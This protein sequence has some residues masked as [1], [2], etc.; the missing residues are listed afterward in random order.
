MYPEEVV[1]HGR[2][3]TKSK[4]KGEAIVTRQPFMFT[5]ALDPKTGR[6]IDRRHELFGEELRGKVFVFPYPVGS[7]SAGMWLLEAVRLGNAPMAFVMEEIDPVL[8]IGA[9]LAEIMLDK[10][11]PVVDRLR[12]SPC[13]VFHTGDEVEVDADLGEVRKIKG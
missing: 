10:P 11:I 9:F 7:T 8:A 4:A 1:L 2:G 13:E 6:V 3:V 5:H 12:P